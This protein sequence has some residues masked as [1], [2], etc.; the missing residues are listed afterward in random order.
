M[1]PYREIRFGQDAQLLYYT[2]GMWTRYVI[3]FLKRK[4]FDF[5]KPIEEFM[6]LCGRKVYRQKREIVGEYDYEP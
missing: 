2:P 5:D 4:G 1:N 3:P 6:D